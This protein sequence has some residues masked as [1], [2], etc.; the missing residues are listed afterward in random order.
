MRMTRIKVNMNDPASFPEGK[1]D[2]EK[3]DAIT[4]EEIAQHGAQDDSEAILDAAK[5]ARKVRKRLGLSQAQFAEKIEVAVDTIRN[6]EQG[7]RCPTG[8]AKALLRVLDKIP[9]ASLAAL[10]E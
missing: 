2:W 6:W 4:E 3:F 7:R 1:V 9:E 8:P 10:A 5:F